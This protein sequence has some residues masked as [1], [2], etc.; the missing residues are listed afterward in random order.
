VAPR[1][2]HRLPHGSA[3]LHDDRLL[4]LLQRVERTKVNVKD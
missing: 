4:A 1:R 2:G 3:K